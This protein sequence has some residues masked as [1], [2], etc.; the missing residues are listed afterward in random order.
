MSIALYL[1]A[2]LSSLISQ[3]PSII[4]SGQDSI[5]KLVW[6]LP[7]IYMLLVSPRAYLSNKLMPYYLF[8]FVFAYFCFVSQMFTERKYLSND[9][10][11]VAISFIMTL[12][13]FNFWR[14]YGSD[15]VMQ[16]ICIMM[17]FGG[18]I[19]SINIFFNFDLLSNVMQKSYA[20]GEKNSMGQIL[21]CSGFLPI[22]FY[23][24][25]NKVLYWSARGASIFMFIVMLLL[26]S[27]ATYVSAVVIVIYYA[28]KAK[29]K[30]I[31]YAIITFS[32]LLGA[33]FVLQGDIG[34]V[35]LKGL[36][37][38]GRDSGNINDLSSGRFILILIGI[39]KIPEHIWI[40][41]GHYY[42][43]CFPI[44]ILL[45]YGICG[46]LIFFSFL[47]YIYQYI[48]KHVQRHVIISTTFIL[49]LSFLA[50]GLFEAYPPF[51]PGVKC[52][53]LWMM[54]GFALAEIEKTQRKDKTTKAT[55]ILSCDKPANI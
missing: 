55:E 32:I 28:L 52:F 50:N 29:N 44:A 37:M 9:L 38:G 23:T 12:V 14:K 27:R 53:T 47:F 10:Y 34:D 1:L 45:Q 4:D 30:K 17:L 18:I 3:M 42:L 54:F 2:I 25:T 7:F 20:F 41:S 11:N 5:F 46:I 43:D 33:F 35:V 26:R 51:G 36:I 22:V 15:T 40:G 48:K 39:S 21:L 49:Y 19:L 16:A 31:K 13:S 24:P 6:V 8:L